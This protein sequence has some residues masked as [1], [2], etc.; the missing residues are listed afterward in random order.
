MPLG[1]KSLQSGRNSRACCEWSRSEETSRQEHIQKSLLKQA[2][3]NGRRS[4]SWTAWISSGVRFGLLDAE[5]MMK[6]LAFWQACKRLQ[7][8]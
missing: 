8:E 6:E 7:S 3:G 1:Q 4:S 5:P 2:R